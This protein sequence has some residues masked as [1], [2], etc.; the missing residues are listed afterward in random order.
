M[1]IKLV[2]WIVIALLVIIVGSTVWYLAIPKTPAQTATST[3]A[4]T[5]PASGSVAPTQATT[6]QAQGKLSIKSAAGGFIITNDFIHN[7]V[8]IANTSNPGNYLL[9]GNLGH[10]LSNPE[11]CQAAPVDNFS[12]YYYGQSQVFNITLTKEPI[13]Q[14]RL[15][16]ENFLLQ[17]LGI[18]KTQMCNL[19]Y[20]VGVTVYLNEQYAGKNLGFSFCPGATVLP[21]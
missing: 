15:D 7:G 17:E 6:T 1:Q 19:D 11:L 12:V 10:C 21:K 4:V 9:A 2:G 20:S 3:P 5:L 18:T 14:A 13:G 16:A 8:T